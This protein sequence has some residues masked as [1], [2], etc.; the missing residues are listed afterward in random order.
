[1]NRSA[2][3]LVAL[4]F[5]VAL[6]V[7]PVV[8]SAT[9]QRVD[10]ATLC[11]AKVTAFPK[12]A[13]SLPWMSASYRARFSSDQLAA[14]VLNCEVKLRPAPTAFQAE[15]AVVGLNKTNGKSFQNQNMWL[16]NTAGKLTLQGDFIALGIPALTLEDGP[17]GIIYRPPARDPQPTNFPNELALGASMNPALAKSFGAQLGLEANQM[18]YMGVQAPDL[19]LDR[20]PNWGRIA[21]TFGEDPVLSGEMGAQETIGLLQNT[22]VVVLKHFG[23][24]GQETNRKTVNDVLTSA[25]ARPMVRNGFRK[26]WPTMVSAPQFTGSNACARS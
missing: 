22:H 2:R 21:E 17:G 1:M 10:A 18:H 24:Y 19:N 9:S 13:D 3:S 12:S 15:L 23:L 25:R 20:I 7:S 5:V 16:A 4:G 14:Q 8:V 6:A 26:T 11:P